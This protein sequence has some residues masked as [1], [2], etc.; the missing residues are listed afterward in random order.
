[1][2][3]K[4]FKNHRDLENIRSKD[5]LTCSVNVS[6]AA[7]GLAT[8]LFWSVVLG[9]HGCTWPSHPR[10]RERMG[11]GRARKEPALALASG[12][13]CGTDEHHQPCPTSGLR[14]CY[15][16]SENRRSR[17]TTTKPRPGSPTPQLTLPVP[18]GRLAWKGP[19]SDPG[20]VNQN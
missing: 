18:R 14:T 19:H 4:F 12:T 15:L 3:W 13:P 2:L 1:M 10:G 7:K 5:A 17:R 16:E 8:S 6:S 11:G 20:V 9:T